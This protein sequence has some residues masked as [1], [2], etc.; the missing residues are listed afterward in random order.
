MRLLLPP[1]TIVEGRADQA[2]QQSRSVPTSDL[3]ENSAIGTCVID[4]G[5]A[6]AA[7]R[8][9]P[10]T[11]TTNTKDLTLVLYSRVL[12]VAGPIATLKHLL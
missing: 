9:R 2:V 6:R 5:G 7:D 8:G 1:S 3:L 4:H 10:P 12:L 11:I